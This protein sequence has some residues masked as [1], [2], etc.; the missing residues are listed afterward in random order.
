M[1]LVWSRPYTLDD[2]YHELT[3]F[4]VQWKRADGD[5]EVAA[6]VSEA[7]VEPLPRATQGFRIEGLQD[8]VEYEVRVIAVNE[9]GP[10]EPSDVAF[11]TVSST[12]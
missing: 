11:A 12:Q 3:D 9:T 2:K 10:G 6:D 1:L 5:W 7:A 4:R 8:G